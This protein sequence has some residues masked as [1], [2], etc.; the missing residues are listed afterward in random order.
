MFS[1]TGNP[2][3]TLWNGPICGTCG[4]RYLNAHQCSDADLARRIG[5]LAG[6]MKGGV[7]PVPT[8]PADRMAHC[9]CRPENGGSGVCGCI[10]AGQGILNCSVG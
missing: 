1:T 10:L 6:L 5:E 2:D 4:A 3:A 8:K 7:R 9:P